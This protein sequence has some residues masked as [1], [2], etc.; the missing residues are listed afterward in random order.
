M[1]M[2]VCFSCGARLDRDHDCT[3]VVAKR[4]PVRS[5]RS[6]R[7][8]GEDGSGRPVLTLIRTLPTLP[9]LFDPPDLPPI[10]AA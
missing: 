8:G 9:T 1:R 4:L 2:V 6:G 10:T 7:P 3:G 5:E